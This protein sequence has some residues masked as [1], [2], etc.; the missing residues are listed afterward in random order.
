[1]PGDLGG[2]RAL[3][4][5]PARPSR[6]RAAGLY[7]VRELA[8]QRVPA[9]CDLPSAPRGGAGRAPRGA[10]KRSL[11]L[12]PFPPRRTLGHPSN[13]SALLPSPAFLVPSQLLVLPPPLSRYSSWLEL[14]RATPRVPSDL[15]ACNCEHYRIQKHVDHTSVRLLRYRLLVQGTRGSKEREGGQAGS[16]W[17]FQTLLSAL[18][19]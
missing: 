8:G 14:G 3:S 7:I 1:M 19:F 12:F 17:S 15:P 2:V 13:Q 5:P 4:P 9:V 10:E 18:N 6:C 11:L 16:P